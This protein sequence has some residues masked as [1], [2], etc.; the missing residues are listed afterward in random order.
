MLSA[1]AVVALKVIR[2][3]MDTEDVVARYLSSEYGRSA[4]QEWA[5]GDEPGDEAVDPV[6]G[7][8]WITLHNVSKMAS[9]D[10]ELA[11]AYEMKV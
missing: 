6:G 11:K 8:L 7:L 1:V 5:S 10:P 4:A 2:A 3:G 9:F